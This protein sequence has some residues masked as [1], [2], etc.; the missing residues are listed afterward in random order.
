MA[1]SVFLENITTWNIQN[2]S[3]GIIRAILDHPAV[4]EFF[5]EI[6]VKCEV[7][8]DERMKAFTLIAILKMYIQVCLF[9]RARILIRS[10]ECLK[11]LRRNI[12]KTS[13]E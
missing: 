11:L 9:S 4:I 8:P 6:V 12:T 1:K 7:K 13:E 2:S 3:W 5:A 10:F